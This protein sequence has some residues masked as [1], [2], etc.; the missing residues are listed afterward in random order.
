MP[1]P[2]VIK[3]DRVPSKDNRR[4]MHHLLQ[5]IDT[6]RG[7]FSM[8]VDLIPRTRKGEPEA[9]IYVGSKK[10]VSGYASIIPELKKAMARVTSLGG[11]DDPVTSYLHSAITVKDSDEPSKMDTGRSEKDLSSAFTR[12]T[13]E[14]EK[15]RPQKGVSRNK[16]GEPPPEVR[17]TAPTQSRGGA[18]APRMQEPRRESNFGDSH[19]GDA[20]MTKRVMA[21]ASGDVH[22]NS[23]LAGMGGMD[24]VDA[25]WWSNQFVTAGI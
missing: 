10:P 22:D 9:M 24:S 5:E 19:P 2:I 4:I 25:K 17:S 18:K 16:N 23:D 15:R 13:E 20:M 7:T 14:R 21:S 1:I 12:A 6:Y 3:L 8:R 11:A